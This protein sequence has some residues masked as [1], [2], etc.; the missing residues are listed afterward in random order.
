MT[1]NH[2]VENA[3]TI[4]VTL[5]SGESF[6]AVLRAGDVQTD[7]AVIRIAPS[8]IDLRPAKL[9]DSSKLVVGQPVL[10]IGH[11]LAIPGG[12]I[13]TDGIVSATGVSIGSSPQLTLIDVILHTAPINPG[14]SG[15]PLVNL[16]AEVVGI[17]TA[18]I[19]ETRGIG[20]AINV[21]DA[22]LV[23]DQIVEFGEVRR[24]YVG[25]T[26][27]NVSAELIVQLGIVL[28]PDVRSGVLVTDVREGSPSQEADMQSG[29]VIVQIDQSVIK[30]TGELSKFLLSHPPGTPVDITF[31]R[32]LQKRTVEVVLSEQP[33]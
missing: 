10:A 21:N 3:Q 18:I 11:A 22:E 32:G 33:Q 14:N 9:G 27:L 5:P 1:N 12:P 23:A 2:L 13:V 24:G 30:N 4:I 6:F 26:P 25:I 29:D 19:E 17:N 16:R 15:G 20:F 31:Y 28:P 8:G 7:T